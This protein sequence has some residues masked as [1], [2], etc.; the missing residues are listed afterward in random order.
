MA[1]RV[2]KSGGSNLAS[3]A[4]SA[5]IALALVAVNS[6]EGEYTLTL[7]DLASGTTKTEKWNWRSD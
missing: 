1:K 7:T 3:L 6:A 2:E 4:L 5:M